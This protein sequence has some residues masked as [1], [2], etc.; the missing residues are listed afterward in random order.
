MGGF[1]RT[2]WKNEA[3]GR[4]RFWGILNKEAEIERKVEGSGTMGSSSECLREQ[5][6]KTF[7][8]DGEAGKR[9]F[10]T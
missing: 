7:L 5:S 6:W 4:G 9:D 2:F 10:V 1:S 3:G 8:G